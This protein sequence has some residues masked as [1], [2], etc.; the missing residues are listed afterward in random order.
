MNETCFLAPVHSKG[1]KYGIDY[2]KSYNKFYNDDHLYLVFSNQ[3]EMND[4]RYLVGS[5]A[6]YRPILCTEHLTYSKPIS[7]KKI[8]GVNYVFQT[9]SFNQVAVTDV[10][11]IFVKHVNYDQLMLDRAARSKFFTSSSNNTDVVNKVGRAAAKKFFT[12]LD[13]KKLET[14]TNGFTDYFWFNDIPVYSRE[15]FKLFKQ[16]INYPSTIDKLEYTTFDFILYAYYLLLKSYAVI[17]PITVNGNRPPIQDKG[18]FIESQ[19]VF[20]PNYFKQAIEQFRPMWLIDL[21]ES[22]NQDVMIKL[23]VDR[24]KK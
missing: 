20:N 21:I 19:R 7:Q 15:Y 14:L 22:D 5:E 24:I 13:V 23:H 18:S 10:D 11:C 2:V 4:F 3:D 12:P 16:Y 8:F 6:R 1:F 9:T 17:E